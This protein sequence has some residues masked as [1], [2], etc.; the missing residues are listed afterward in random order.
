MNLHF[1][2][3]AHDPP[4]STC[5]DPVGCFM[6]I[7]AYR[8][9]R[10]WS[11]HDET[12]SPV[13]AAFM[14]TWNDGL[15]SDQERARILSPFAG[16]VINSRADDAVENQRAYMA[17]DWLI[18]TYTPAFLDLVESCHEHA[19]ALRA[20]SEIADLAT[21]RAASATGNAAWAAAGNA[22]R[23]AAW[24]A[25]GNAARDAAGN[26]AWAAAGNAARVAAW[27]AAGNA[28]WVAAWA[29]AGNAAWVAAWAA[30]GNA[31]RDAAGNA[32]RDAAGNA[33]GNAAW[34]AAVLRPVVDSLQVSAA[35]LV[36]RMLAAR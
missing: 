9:G 15:S 14:R 18:R 10:P 12:A 30:A 2:K 22:A 6:E 11:D 3:G 13:I 35:D 19:T 26:A 20:L 31:A 28:A 17:L 34:V 24:A 23:D 7:E 21:A 27:A 1:H 32:A 29:A 36:E 8:A 5:T 16:R 4:P 25:A 33:A